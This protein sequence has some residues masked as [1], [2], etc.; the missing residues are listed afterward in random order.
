MFQKIVNGCAIFS[1]VVSLAVVG[2]VGFVYIN[3][4]SIVDNVKKKVV[5]SILPSVPLPTLPDIT[6]GAVTGAAGGL[7]APSNAVPALPKF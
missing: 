5:E 4:D 2:T 6:G 1:G 3:K 7:A